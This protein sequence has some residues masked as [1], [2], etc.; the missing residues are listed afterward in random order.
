MTAVPARP[1]PARADAGVRVR[2][3]ELPVARVLVDVSLAHLDR[4][5]DYLVAE[6]D[7]ASAQPGV[8]I[9]VRFAG[10]LVGGY[11]L[12]RTA[13]SEDPGPLGFVERVVS[14]EPVL[15]PEITDLAR[16]V[17]ERYAG[18]TADVLRLAVPPRH[19]KTEDEA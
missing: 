16:A 7:S 17:A 8:R 9:R 5:Y 13:V 1:R 18:S 15:H 10:R 3:Q 4:P 2:A 12:Q 14:P 11:V 6:S 19:A